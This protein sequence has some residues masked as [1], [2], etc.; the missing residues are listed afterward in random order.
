[1]RDLTL[2]WPVTVVRPGNPLSRTIGSVPFVVET[3]A[4]L[5]GERTKTIYPLDRFA[6]CPGRPKST[7]SS[8]GPDRRRALHGQP[9]WCYTSSGKQ[10]PDDHAPAETNMLEISRLVRQIHATPTQL[11]L[12]LAGG[13]SA[14]IGELLQVS[15]A[16]RTVLEA[17]VPY[18]AGS[19]REF[20]GGPPEQAC[21]AQ[22]ARAMAMAAFLRARRLAGG[23]KTSTGEALAGVACTASLASDRPKR[24]P[25]RAHL[26]V[27]TAD[28]TASASV[29]L[30]KGHR[31]RALEEEVVCRL[32][33]NHVAFAC[34]L[35]DE[36][37]LGLVSS[38]IVETSRTDAQPNW[39]DLLLG[40]IDLTR[41]GSGEFSEDPSASLAILPGAFN[42]LHDA[43]RKMAEMA[44]RLLGAKV[45]FELSIEN[46][47]KPPLDY[48]QI[49]RRTSQ[50]DSEA[51]L[52]L[53]RAATFVEKARL[54]PGVTFV[55]GADTILRVADPRYF[56]NDTAACRRAIEEIAQAGCR[57]LVFGRT[58]S[59][60]FR[61][62]GELNLP[63]ELH[64]LCR[65][66]PQSEFRED[67]S[68]TELRGRRRGEE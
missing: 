21:S 64:A 38:E 7:A 26:A 47:D 55:V 1:M 15:G 11:V 25:H 54:F 51:A 3:A 45:L 41:V 33:L 57:F 2:H 22:T 52:Y 65:E 17:V 61:S 20:L 27:Q 48:S 18:S 62:L 6:T 39:K 44:G 63:P 34:G 12:S 35:P 31:T 67:I 13:G 14:A 16:S 8:G 19:L 36:L 49:A 4:G 68:S 9:R 56:R 30:E 53:T 66:V 42:P 60:G 59:H 23:E 10:R 5:L 24:G 32:I 50:F 43:H 40:R 29:E 46:V 58:D 28:F 37:P